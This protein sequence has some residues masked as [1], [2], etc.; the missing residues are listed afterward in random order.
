MQLNDCLDDHEFV[1]SHW[2]VISF[3]TLAASCLRCCDGRVRK[4]RA[5]LLSRLV[6]LASLAAMT[7]SAERL[8][9]QG[10]QAAPALDAV[11]P[12]ATFA[13]SNSQ[14]PSVFAPRRTAPSQSGS[15]ATTSGLRSIERRSA[16]PA[17]EGQ[18]YVALDVK[19]ARIDGGR[20]PQTIDELRALE[21]QQSKVAAAIQKVTVNVRQGVAQGSGVLISDGYVLTAAHVG[22]KPR[23]TATVVLSDGTELKAEVLGMNRNVDAGLLKIIDEKAKDLPYATLGKS[24][25]L[26]AGHWVIGSG[27]PGGWASGRGAVIR[28]GRVLSVQSDTLISDVALI[29]G[30]S[31]GPL[32]N[33]R[34]ELIGIHSRI[35]T[36]I[37][38]NMHV[39]IDTFEHD[40]A[41][42]KNS[43]AWGVLPGYAP[44][45][46]VGAKKGESRAVL[47]DVDPNGPAHKAGLRAGDI[48]LKFDGQPIQT[49]AELQN[50]VRTTL[51]GDAVKIEVQRGNDVSRFLIVVGVAEQ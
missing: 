8:W 10:F 51:P 37:V 9:S 24:H 21:A 2:A 6:I 39:P 36:D 44:V 40:W 13:P 31:G 47:G 42:L 34:G 5:S 16:K 23:R 14:S 41:R 19:L 29:G 17:I 22:G 15:P 35:G 1:T 45:I 43:E 3:N 18:T 32:F 38:D 11:A 30:D 46:G 48:V 49:F 33:L 12:P 26:K 50:A 27:H 20:A 7:S 28:V 25:E 4:S